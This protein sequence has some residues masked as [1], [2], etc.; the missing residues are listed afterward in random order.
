MSMYL[1]SKYK[2]ESHK[3]V[4]LQGHVFPEMLADQGG[5]CSQRLL[6]LASLHKGQD[7]QNKI[8]LRGTN[9]DPCEQIGLW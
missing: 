9:S 7:T 8:S 4:G 5:Y 1:L 6:F 3:T 2:E